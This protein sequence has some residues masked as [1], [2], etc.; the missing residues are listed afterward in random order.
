MSS[1]S[2]DEDAVRAIHRGML[3]AWNDGSSERF[4]A[5]FTDDADFVAF[6][7]THLRG[8]REIDA[9]HKQIFATVVK[10]SRLEGEVKFVRFL[11]PDLAVMH[12]VVRVFLAGQSVTSA[13]RDSMQLYVVVQRDGRWQ[14][15]ELMNARH[16]TI[17]SQ[18]LLDEI[19]ALPAAAQHQVAEL[20]A[21]L[22]PQARHPDVA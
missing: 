7:G 19:V 10:G 14:T 21:A 12:S 11:A 2:T 8:R 20:V 15:Q 1:F 4:S 22:E 9:F 6:E 3:E 5:S 18:E 16:L 17:E 13:S